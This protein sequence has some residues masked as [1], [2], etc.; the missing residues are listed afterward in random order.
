M[1]YL[2]ISAALLFRSDRVNVLLRNIVTNLG[3]ISGC[4]IEYCFS[5]PKMSCNVLTRTLNHTIP[6]ISVLSDYLLFSAVI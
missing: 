4:V 1:A 6:Y 3:T 2:F 5:V